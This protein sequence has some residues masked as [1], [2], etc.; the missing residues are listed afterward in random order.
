MLELVLVCV[1]AVNKISLQNDFGSAKVVGMCIVGGARA[2][3][4][5]ICG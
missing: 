5:V 2:L 3:I 1:Y 4:P